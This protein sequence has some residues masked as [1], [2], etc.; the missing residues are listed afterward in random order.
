MVPRENN[1][2]EGEWAA[3]KLGPSQVESWPSEV[4]PDSVWLYDGGGGGAQHVFGPGVLAL[5]ADVDGERVATDRREAGVRESG[6]GRSC[7]LFVFGAAGGAAGQDVDQDDFRVG[8]PGR[9]ADRRGHFAGLRGAFAM[10]PDILECPQDLCSSAPSL[11]I[12]R[13][14]PLAH[15]LALARSR[16]RLAKPLAH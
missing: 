7:A 16:S 13:S 2:P 5:T 4:D 12:V 14:C 11:A 15:W 10:A 8:G 9:R 3:F 6:A 1:F